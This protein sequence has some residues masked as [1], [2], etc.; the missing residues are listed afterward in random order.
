MRTEKSSVLDPTD[1]ECGENGEVYWQDPQDCLEDWNSLP[2][3]LLDPECCADS[4][5]L[6]LKTFLF[7]QYYSV[8]R[9]RGF[10]RECAI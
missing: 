4:H 3:G 6:S 2:E 8:Q 5:R 10:L 1:M 9:I 7:S